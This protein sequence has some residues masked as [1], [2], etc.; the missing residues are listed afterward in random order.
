MRKRRVASI[1]LAVLTC[2]STVGLSSC[3]QKEE[4][5]TAYEIAVENGFEGTEQEWLSSLK[6]NTGADGAD[7]TVQDLYE[8]SGFEGTLEE[9]IDYYMTEMDFPVQED[10]DTETIAKNTS[11]VVTIC[12]G[13]Q[14]SI[15]VR[16][17][18]GRY[19]TQTKVSASEGSGVIYKM[20]TNGEYTEAYIITNYH[21][22]YGGSAYTDNE[23]G[24]SSDMYVY[25]YGA[26]ELFTKGDED[27]DGYLDDGATMG[28]EGDGLRATLVGGAMDYDIA[29]LKVSDKDYLPKSAASAATLGNSDE[30][31][32]GEKAFAIGN[33][34]GHGISVTSGAISVES[35][36]ITMT[37]TDVKRTVTYR[38]MR[39][40]AA[41]NAGNSGGGL[42]NAQGELIGITNA[43]NIQDQTDNM[44]YALPITK[45]KFIIDN[46]LS[47]T[48]NG[49]TGYVMRPWLGIETYLQSSV[50]SLVDG[51]LEIKETFLVNKVL[52]D[53]QAG[54]G[55]GKF[56]YMDI[57]TGM[58]IGDGDW[59]TFDRKYQFEDR[60]LNI[61]KG[62]TV[63]FKVLRENVETEVSVAFDKDEYFIQYA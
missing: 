31:T 45:V 30:V 12:A 63:V 51:K 15:I 55:A 10:N 43:K 38:V 35:E 48:P 27:D 7:L 19:Q 26:R 44:G 62:D 36:T 58:K 59:F 54:A 61:R 56:E 41:I 4:A 5:I 8:A 50:A 17:R 6:G 34:N 46:I 33:A 42:F 16:D 14:K 23:N 1:T 29:I 9:F 28:D 20:E 53:E 39:T 49:Q 37:S 11:S 47:N 60:M 18:W 21:V 52:S 25:T 40:D 13:F 24:I 57:I 32:L 22:V 3:F 2:V